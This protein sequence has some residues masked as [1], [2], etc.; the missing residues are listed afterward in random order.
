MIVEEI[1]NACRSLAVDGQWTVDFI[2]AFQVQLRGGQHLPASID[3]PCQDFLARSGAT[4]TF[5]AT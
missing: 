4:C 1:W 3:A 2:F 5:C